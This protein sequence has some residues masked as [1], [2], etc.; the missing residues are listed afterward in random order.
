M[1]LP[2][3]WC[4]G[5]AAAAPPDGGHAVRLRGVSRGQ[6]NGLNVPEDRIQGYATFEW[7]ELN[8]LQLAALERAGVAADVRRD[9]FVLR[10]GGRSFDPVRDV[11]AMPP[12]W[13][14]IREDVPDLHVV[15]FAGPARSSWVSSLENLGLRIVQHVAPHAYVVWGDARARRRAETLGPVRWSGPFVNGY[16]V[17]PPWRNLEADPVEVNALVFRGAALE[18]VLAQAQ[19]LGA[20]IRGR[21]LLDATFEHVIFR[22]PGN[23]LQ[24][25]SKIPGVYTLQPVPTDG[26]LRG[27][28]SNQVCAGNVTGGEAFPGY[29][30]WLAG[31]SLSGTGVVVASVDDGADDTHPDLVDR[32]LPC[33]GTTCATGN[34]TDPHGTHTAGIIAADGSSGVLDF[35]GFLRGLGMAPGAN[36]V[37]QNYKSFI[38]SAGMLQLMRDSFN[39]GA[40]LSSNSWGSSAVPQG[41]DIY[42]RQVD[43]GVRDVDPDTAGNQSLTYVL[44]IMNGNGSA[45][46]GTGTQGSPDEAKNIVTVGSTWMQT[47]TGALLV[48]LDD[49]SENTAH[50]PAEDGRIIPHLVA[51]GCWVDS[52]ALQQPGVAHKLICGTSMAAPH[53]AGAAALF[54]EHYRNLTGGLDPSPALIKAALLVS[55]RDL[56]GKLDADGNV[57]SHPFNSRQ[58]WG[59]LDV[60]AMLDPALS[61]EYLDLPAIPDETGNSPIILNESGEEWVTQLAA[62]DLDRPMRIMLVWTDAPGHGQGGAQP[63]WNND[64]DLV[65]EAGTNTYYGNVFDAS[66]WSTPGGVADFRNNTEGVFL[67]PTAPA[68]VTVH[69]V[70]AD[71][72]SDGVPGSGDGTD[73][74]FALV[75]TNCSRQP[76][77]TLGVD[78]QEQDACAGSD[79]VY[80]IDVSQITDFTEQVTLSL[81][82]APPNATFEFSQ[83]P[84]TPPASS[85]L[86]IHSSAATPP[87]KYVMILQGDSSALMRTLTLE[88]TLVGDTP[89]AVSLTHPADGAGN[90][91]LQPTVIWSTASQRLVYD[92]QVATDEAFADLIS[93]AA[94]IG[95]SFFV[96][97]PSLE[98]DRDYFWRVRAHNACGAGPFSGP[99]RFTTR[100]APGILLVDDD[101]N[102]PNV[103]SYYTAALEMLSQSYSLWSTF[104]SDNEPTLND[105][106]NYSSVIWFTG[107]SGATETSDGTGPGAAGELALGAY[108]DGG[109]CLLLES[110]DYHFIRGLRDFMK[111]YLGVDF[112]ENDAVQSQVIGAGVVFSDLGPLGLAFPTGL[113]NWSDVIL[114]NATAEVAFVGDV[115]SAAINKDSGS[116]RTTYWGFPLAAVSDGN[117][118]VE[119][120]DRFVRWCAFPPSGDCNGNGVADTMELIWG[121]ATDCNGN[122]KPDSCDINS[123]SSR[124][125][126][127]DSVPDECSRGDIDGNDTRDLR[128]YAALQSCFGTTEQS[129]GADPACLLYFDFDESTAVDL[130]DHAAF[131][132]VFEGP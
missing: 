71:I 4:G 44:A 66:G 60:A 104:N 85:V 38:S 118:R 6:L 52:T 93:S 89:D 63:A 43:V 41:Y 30:D 12:G 108:L 131:H 123:G 99:F 28:M 103:Q 54:I 23:K 31:R 102:A 18:G 121:T 83:N 80:T 24:A 37:E 19:G 98:P 32:F 92:V 42:A 62:V 39:N 112:V 57:M 77:F 111:S 36:L 87:G 109:G 122:A 7:T 74:D 20:A 76:R 95:Q 97:S 132:Q 48:A 64:L 120:I 114:P 78:R 116:Y 82:A 73:Q 84:V 8:D 16:R 26:G 59:R 110:Q 115:G 126:N 9:A 17:Q 27:E 53:V 69:V 21:G 96:V 113:A 88:L 79:T 47:S 105:L 14:E 56:A 125:A 91:V 13:G 119:F 117:A 22:L 101:N 124:D 25:A 81:S 107:A 58:G 67:G 65:V 3:A 130:V 106:A 51:P 55:A 33:V 15:Q 29:L 94:E 90:I 129:P 86:T 11:P 50:G 127:D 75:C 61:V 49:L 72:N 68:L 46:D 34:P 2:V 100:L 128:D 40:A 70:A 5:L 10:L 1:L 35:L 45:T